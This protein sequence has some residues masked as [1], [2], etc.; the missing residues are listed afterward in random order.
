MADFFKDSFDKPVDD[1]NL[2]NVIPELLTPEAPLLAQ[3]ELNPPS[4]PNTPTEIRAGEDARERA[5]RAGRLPKFDKIIVRERLRE[6]Y[7]DSKCNGGSWACCWEV[8]GVMHCGWM[9]EMANMDPDNCPYRACCFPNYFGQPNEYCPDPDPVVR[10]V[11]GTNAVKDAVENAGK[12]A[13]QKEGSPAEAGGGASGGVGAGVWGGGEG[14][15][16]P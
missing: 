9:M 4:I 11:K 2:D 13:I 5:E 7:D 16:G 14:G 1:G 15:A 3:T 8:R 12:D 10:A 6:G